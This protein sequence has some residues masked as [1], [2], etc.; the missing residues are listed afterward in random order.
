MTDT[1]LDRF[2]S[3]HFRI[4]RAGLSR[5]LTITPSEEFLNYLELTYEN[6]NSKISI[7][8]ILPELFG[9]EENIL[10]L[11]SDH[12]KTLKIP[13]ISRTVK[14]GDIYFN[15]ILAH[16]PHT[17]T[18]FLFVEDTTERMVFEWEL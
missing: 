11:L 7:F 8:D 16:P 12:D 4:F 6:A 3:A 9:Y 15:I 10:E 1:H 14:R 18:I 2:I 13:N 17:K 5:D